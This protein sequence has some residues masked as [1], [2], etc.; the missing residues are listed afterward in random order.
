VTSLKAALHKLAWT[1]TS[2]EQ[3]GEVLGR[4]PFIAKDEYLRNC[5]KRV[6]VA[7]TLNLRDQDGSQADKTNDVLEDTVP[8]GDDGL[9]AFEEARDPAKDRNDKRSRNNNSSWTDRPDKRAKEEAITC[10][11]CQQTGHKQFQCPSK[12]AGNPRQD[13]PSEV[14]M[15]A[16]RAYLVRHDE[17]DDAQ[18]HGHDFYD[19]DD[20][21]YAY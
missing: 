19:R 12:R 8:Q 5:F 11:W 17:S 10:F 13:R 9:K 7:M 15:K 14:Y 3:D 20:P 2:Q 1:L 21:R 18:A 6:H 4:G 16:I